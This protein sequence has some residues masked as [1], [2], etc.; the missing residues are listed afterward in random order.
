M[1]ILFNQ[2]VIPA[3]RKGKKKKKVISTR[4]FNLPKRKKGSRKFLKNSLLPSQPGLQRE[5]FPRVYLKQN[6][7]TSRLQVPIFQSSEFC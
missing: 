5:G 2:I 6:T 7:K 1:L 4:Y 3:P